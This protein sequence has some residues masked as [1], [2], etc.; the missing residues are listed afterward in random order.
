MSSLVCECV[1]DRSEHNAK[2]V[3]RGKLTLKVL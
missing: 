1:Y 3:H 2:A